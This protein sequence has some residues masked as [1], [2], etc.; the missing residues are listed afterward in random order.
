MMG[1]DPPPRRPKPVYNNH[2]AA[3]API[4][5]NIGI[6]LRNCENLAT[7]LSA[8]ERDISEKCMRS[9]GANH[10]PVKAK[11]YLDLNNYENCFP[12]SSVAGPTISKQ[13]IESANANST[14]T[15]D[16]D[17]SATTIASTLNLEDLDL[18]F[19]GHFESSGERK[20]RELC[21]NQWCGGVRLLVG[22][23]FGR[24]CVFC[25]RCKVWV[26]EVN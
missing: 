16:A 12:L 20:R 6:G 1:Y 4:Y 2:K 21:V 18:D 9:V 11:S 19:G 24:L 15:A 13:N 23:V 14:N 26:F 8:S 3:A 10:R 17:S 25:G 7:V 22:R 5:E